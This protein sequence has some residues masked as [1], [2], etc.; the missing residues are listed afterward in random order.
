MQTE[1]IWC[2]YV[3]KGSS[4]HTFQ[5]KIPSAFHVGTL[6]LVRSSDLALGRRKVHF[7]GGEPLKVFEDGAMWGFD[8]FFFFNF[9]AMPHRIACGILVP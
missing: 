6:A 2:Y 5:D 3:A 9:L 1:F 4:D 8:L 7:G